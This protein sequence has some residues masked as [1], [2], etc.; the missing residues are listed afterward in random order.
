MHGIG[1]EE[2]EMEQRFDGGQQ[3]VLTIL[4][5][6]CEAEEA[7]KNMGTIIATNEESSF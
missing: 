5:G 4:V 3:S 1:T 2:N 6:W 7:R